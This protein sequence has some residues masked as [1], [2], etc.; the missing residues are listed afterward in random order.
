[1]SDVMEAKQF[2]ILQTGVY[3]QGVIGPFDSLQKAKGEAEAM[4]L[5]DKDDYHDY[6][7]HELPIDL[8]SELVFRIDKSSAQQKYLTLP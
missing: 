8:G 6:E 5:A 1:M 2:I 3:I 4:A 7:V